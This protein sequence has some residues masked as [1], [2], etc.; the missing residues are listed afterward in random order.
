MGEYHSSFNLA[1]V[2]VRTFLLVKWPNYIPLHI[3]ICIN[4]LVWFHGQ[5]TEPNQNQTGPISNHTHA[6]VGVDAKLGY[7][8]LL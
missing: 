6:F 5:E 4:S 8:T 2:D 3:T 7:T 1:K